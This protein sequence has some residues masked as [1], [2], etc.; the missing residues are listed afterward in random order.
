VIF[1]SV[2][3]SINICL[4]SKLSQRILRLLTQQHEFLI[5]FFYLCISVSSNLHL[6]II[7]KISDIFF[8]SLMHLRFRQVPPLATP[9]LHVVQ[10]CSLLLVLSSRANETISIPCRYFS[11]TFILQVVRKHPSRKLYAHGPWYVL[12]YLVLHIHC[13]YSSLSYRC[14]TAFTLLHDL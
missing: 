4:F 2:M 12:I 5:W 13:F 1:A 11:C 6:W 9:I 3:S 10:Q 7:N 8:T 14:D